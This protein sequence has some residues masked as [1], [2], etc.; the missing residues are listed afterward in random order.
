MG[1]SK[2]N[3]YI[4]NCL[5]IRSIIK[6]T[7]AIRVIYISI[8]ISPLARVRGTRH[9]FLSMQMIC[10]KNK[11]DKKKKCTDVCVSNRRVSVTVQQLISSA[12]PGGLFP[13]LLEDKAAPM[14]AE[15]QSKARQADKQAADLMKE[16]ER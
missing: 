10:L 11:Y 7:I 1:I 14:E 9:S 3:I 15:R 16:M 8:R 12:V 4:S 2:M 5:L 13:S 6:F